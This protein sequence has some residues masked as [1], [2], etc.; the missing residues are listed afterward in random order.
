[1]CFTTRNGMKSVLIAVAPGQVF[2][3]EAMLNDSHIRRAPAHLFIASL[4]L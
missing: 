1:M 4:D 2:G 3:P